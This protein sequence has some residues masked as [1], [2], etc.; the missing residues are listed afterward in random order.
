MTVGEIR[1]FFLETLNTVYPQSEA[2][3][4][5]RFM[6]EEVLQLSA[7]YQSL[8]V[9]LILTAA[10]KET[11]ENY[12]V[13]LANHEPFQHILGYELFH[14]LKLEVGPDVLIPRP[15]TEELVEWILEAET[16]PNSILDIGTGSGCIAIALAKSL[17]D[18]K[19]E[20]LEVSEKAVAVAKRNAVNNDVK[21]LVSQMDILK[22]EPERNYDLIVSNPPYVGLDEKNLMFP[23][24]LEHEPHLALFSE[25]PLLFYKRIAL[26]AEEHLNENGWL[27]FEMNEFYAPQIAEILRELHFSEIEI[28]RDLSGKD[29]MI[30]GK[31]GRGK[32]K[33]KS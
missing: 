2:L 3:A 29:R 17:P 10:Q 27:Y 6:L 9:H 1:K 11:L 31:K 33:V 30:R 14:G 7:L 4:I 32:S 22:E 25:D 12:L 28:K 20:A 16:K 13:R 19:V 15:E 23:N 26:L 5:T 21:V 8:N 24:V 18:A